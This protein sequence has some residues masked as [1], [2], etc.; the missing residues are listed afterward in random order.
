M[1]NVL[2]SILLLGAAIFVVGCNT[3]HGIGKDVERAGEKV[4]DL[5]KR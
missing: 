1:K 2:A 4:Q 5:S 3:I